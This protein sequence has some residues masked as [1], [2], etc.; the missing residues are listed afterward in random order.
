MLHM[1][2]INALDL[3]DDGT[4][5]LQA[6][7]VQRRQDG[8]MIVEGQ[9]T[10]PL[11]TSD[12]GDSS[13]WRSHYPIGSY[14]SGMGTFCENGAFKK[15]YE[16]VGKNGPCEHHE[17]RGSVEDCAGYY[18]YPADNCVV[19]GKKTC[20]R[21]T[22]A[23]DT[24]GWDNGYGETCMDYQYKY[25]YR[26]VFNTSFAWK[27]AEQEGAGSG[28]A[29]KLTSTKT[30]CAMV[31]NYPQLNCVGCGKVCPEEMAYKLK[32]IERIQTGRTEA[33]VK[34]K[35]ADK[36]MAERD[37]KDAAKKERAKKEKQKEKKEKRT[38]ERA[39]KRASR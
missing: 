10:P 16:S 36:Y 37:M 22:S 33:D 20:K 26:G 12:P 28:C 11:N 13:G 27:G 38:A 23:D 6:S 2:S 31:Y 21:Y 4:N 39:N 25:C 5:L 14:C 9:Y 1:K 35:M 7:I 32:R 34:K 29:D 3:D 18:N 8:D 24:P 30:N 17:G 15:G 19:C